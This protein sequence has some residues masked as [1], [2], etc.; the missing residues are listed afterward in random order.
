MRARPQLFGG[1]V[2]NVWQVRGRQDQ[3][4]RPRMIT[5]QE[6]GGESERVYFDNPDEE[7]AGAEP[8]SGEGGGRALETR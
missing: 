7:G 2:G 5:G 8:I 1:V 3:H 4:G 6:D